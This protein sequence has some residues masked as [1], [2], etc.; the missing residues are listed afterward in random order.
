M[1]FCS[2]FSLLIVF[3]FTSL[4]VAVAQ[5]SLESLRSQLSDVQKKEAELQARIKQLDED[6][7]PESLEKFFALNGSTRPEELREQRRRQL[8]SEK[9]RVQAQLDQLAQSRARLQTAIATA[10]AAAYQQSALPSSLSPSPAVNSNSNKV[11]PKQGQQRP[12]RQKRRV[13][14]RG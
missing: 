4:A 10:E 9:T 6:M 2:R 5:S 3:A 12:A 13:R 11:A 7:R 8:E 1:K 14:R